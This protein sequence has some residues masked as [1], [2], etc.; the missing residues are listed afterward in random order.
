[1]IATASNALILLA[2]G[3]AIGGGVVLFVIASQDQSPQG[4]ILGVL[5][6]VVAALISA[7]LILGR[8][9]F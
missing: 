4:R 9:W 5:I 7:Y 1:M 6:P 3:T 8:H 2:L